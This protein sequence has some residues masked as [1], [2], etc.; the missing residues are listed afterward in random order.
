MC[1]CVANISNRF[2]S[3]RCHLSRMIFFSFYPPYAYAHTLR[4]PL[5]ISALLLEFEY[6]KRVLKSQKHQWFTNNAKFVSF[7]ISFE[8]FSVN[9]RI[10]LPWLQYKYSNSRRLTLDY[11][12]MG[13]YTYVYLCLVKGC[14]GSICTM[15]IHLTLIPATTPTLPFFVSL[16]SFPYQSIAGKHV[17]KNQIEA[18][19]KC[20]ACGKAIDNGYDRFSQMSTHS[21]HLNIE[22]TAHRMNIQK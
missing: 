12:V 15:C 8:I 11:I 20:L 19:K 10:K 21:L 9:K 4:S 13:I 5:T 6:F 14:S 18:W 1:V 16:T 7:W 17:S 22:L 2:S 3:A